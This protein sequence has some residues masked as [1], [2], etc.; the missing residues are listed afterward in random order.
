MIWNWIVH[1]MGVD[2]GV[3]YGR[4]VWYSFWSGFGSLAL[5]TAVA[6]VPVLLFRKFN[7]EMRWCPRLARHDFAD[8]EHN[9]HHHLCRKHHPLHPGKPVTAAQ[10]QRACHLYLGEKPGKG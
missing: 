2:Y 9:V 4:W 6:G 5:V 1:T 10:I 8:P 7:C 3:P